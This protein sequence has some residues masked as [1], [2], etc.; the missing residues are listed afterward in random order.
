MQLL[1]ALVRLG[2]IW[3]SAIWRAVW[4]SYIIW[5]IGLDKPRA[6]S[7]IVTLSWVIMSHC[8]I[9]TVSLSDY[10][11]VTMSYYVMSDYDCHWSLR[12]LSLLSLNCHC[13]CHYFYSYLNSPSLSPSPS[14]SPSPGTHQFSPPHHQS[15]RYYNFN[16]YSL[17]TSTS[18][19]DYNY[20]L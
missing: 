2:I 20:N 15:P 16:K 12:S 13:H 18:D 19:Y 4:G 14:P 11:H 8:Q 6:L 9:V 5:D 1:S 3:Q 10:V 7:G 17:A